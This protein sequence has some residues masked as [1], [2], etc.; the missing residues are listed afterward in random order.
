MKLPESGRKSQEVIRERKT[1]GETL[2]H[3][4][5]VQVLYNNF[6]LLPPL[7][8]PISFFKLQ[9]FGNLQLLWT[10]IAKNLL[11][12]LLNIPGLIFITVAERSC[13]AKSSYRSSWASNQRQTVPKACMDHLTVRFM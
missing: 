9:Q 11:K 13:Q 10:S 8:V 1:R 4:R 3:H 6:K 7:N 5:G 12:S 2:A